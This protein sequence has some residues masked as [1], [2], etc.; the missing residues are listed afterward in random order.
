MLG[1]SF[2]ILP[3]PC[4]EAV[5]CVEWK[6]SPLS[7]HL[8]MEPASEHGA[9]I[10]AWSQHL[11]TSRVVWVGLSSDHEAVAWLE[12]RLEVPEAASTHPY[13]H[14]APVQSFP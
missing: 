13:R 11:S 7:G 5:C 12:P 10:W 3:L 14:L 4:A 1:S 8:S 2:L 6:G 9:S